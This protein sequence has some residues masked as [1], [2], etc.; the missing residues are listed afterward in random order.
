MNKKIF[1]I[2]FKIFVL[3]AIAALG[4]VLL[5]RN[6]DKIVYVDAMKLM[7]GYKGMEIAKQEYEAKTAVWRNN[8]DSLK[9]ELTASIGDYESKEKMMP[10]GEKLLTEKLLQ[11]KQDQFL[12]YQQAVAEKI[13]QADQELTSKVLQRVNEY[14]KKYGEQKGYSIIMAATQYG[15]II[16]AKEATDITDEVLEGLNREFV[17]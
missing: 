14:V 16:Y 4:I 3:V 17:K 2:V 10:T 7:S 13:Q 11:A 8:V 9:T 12:T 6:T 5:I 15:N 1:D